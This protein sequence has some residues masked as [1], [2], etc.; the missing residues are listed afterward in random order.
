M[1]HTGDDN[2][3]DVMDLIYHYVYFH[4]SSSNCHIVIVVIVRVCVDAI[5]AVQDEK[6]WLGNKIN[7]FSFVYE[8]LSAVCSVRS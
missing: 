6:Q 7:L 3:R 8:C 1:L 4:F 5:A 2:T